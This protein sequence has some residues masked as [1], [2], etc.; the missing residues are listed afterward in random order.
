[1]ILVN[2]SK[3]FFVENL[4]YSKNKKKIFYL[5]RTN[6]YYKKGDNFKSLFKKNKITRIINN[7]NFVFNTRKFNSYQY[8][9]TF[10]INNKFIMSRDQPLVI[11]MLGGPGSGKGTQC[12]LIQEKFDFIHI[13]AG[14][15]LR[16]YLIKCEKNEVNKKHQSIVEDCINNGKIVPVNIT[17]ELMKIKIESEI[18]KRKQL[19]HEQIEE[20]EEIKEKKNSF[21]FNLLDENIY[22]KN[23]D[24]E[25]YHEKLKY[26]N[27]IY[28]NKEVLEILKKNK[29]KQKAKYKF[30]IDG[31]PRNF[32]N[33]NG[34]IKIIGNYAYVHLC[35]FL[36]CDEE[37]MIERCISR[38][39]VSGRVDDN[40]ETLK[41]RFETHKNECIP[42]IN[43]FLNEN[44]CIFINANK[45]IEHVW[46]DIQY[47]FSNM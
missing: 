37:V 31:F 45:N 8:L 47:I 20:R 42:I 30:I 46:N 2:F 4:N 38:G 22:L 36:Y 10:F 23:T 21:S 28:E 5:N 9:E 33:F 25:K 3:V 27:N 12:K 6:V 29:L 41:K 11:F 35:L 44:K 1:M 18:E 14:D 15:C 24:M 26:E 34:W 39:L 43:L 13:S 19:E 7:T 40:M 16:E 32:D 17:L